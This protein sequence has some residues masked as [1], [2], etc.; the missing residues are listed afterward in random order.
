MHRNLTESSRKLRATTGSSSLKI[1]SAPSAQPCEEGT[2]G[3]F[4][5]RRRVAEGRGRIGIRK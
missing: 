3:N 2:D 1:D 5:A 4:G